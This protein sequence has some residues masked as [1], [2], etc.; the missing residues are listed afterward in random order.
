[1]TPTAV[2]LEIDEAGSDEHARHVDRSPLAPTGA[3]IDARD[4]SVCNRHVERLDCAVRRDD[5]PATEAQHAA[6]HTSDS[7]PRYNRRAERSAPSAPTSIPV[8]DAINR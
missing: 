1:M 5:E 7:A 8:G 2:E 4:R 6:T 3:G